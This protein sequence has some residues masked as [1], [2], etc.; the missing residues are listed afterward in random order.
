[1][2]G[3]A[4]SDTVTRVP[5]KYRPSASGGGANTTSTVP[6][7]IATAD[8]RN[9]SDLGV[10]SGMAVEVGSGVGILPRVGG[11]AVGEAGGVVDGDTTVVA[12]VAVTLVTARTVGSVEFP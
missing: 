6:F 10:G 9:L 4:D 7:G 12:T 2:D 11:S 5:S 3:I 1:M 8:S